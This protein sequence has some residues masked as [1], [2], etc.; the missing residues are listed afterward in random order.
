MHRFVWD[1]DGEARALSR[2]ADVIVPFSFTHEYQ[3]AVTVTAY[4]QLEEIAR[5]FLSVCGSDPT[6]DT[7]LAYL[8]RA[9]APY[10]R[11]WGYAE[12]HHND[13]WGYI[14]RQTA[15]P[16]NLI[17]HATPLTAADQARNLTTYK[18]N[19]IL[20]DGRLAFGVKENGMVVSVAL[21]HQSTQNADSVEIGVETA[22]GARQK[23]YATA[24]LVALGGALWECG[25]RAEYRCGRDN[26]ASY[27]VARA[28]GFTEIGK[29][30]RYIG[31][32]VSK[33]GL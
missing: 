27:R 2:A 29:F 16:A 20:T 13:R 21:T 15:A 1:V 11:E 6:A 31:R 7:A 23:G 14:L 32:R 9:L 4:P 24:S 26:V 3:D 5:R 17:A 8:F 18:L 28:A 10:M 19:E 12:D 25:I 33:N 22:V 30:Y